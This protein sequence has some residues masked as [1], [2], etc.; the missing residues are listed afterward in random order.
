MDKFN[1]RRTASAISK[2]ELKFCLQLTTSCVS[3][4]ASFLNVSLN[5]ARLSTVSYVV[6]ISYVFIY[7]FFFSQI[8][9]YC[10]AS[11][12]QKR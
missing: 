7:F 12:Y 5:M 3:F 10:I 4:V 2:R 11:G 1:I 9:F 6:K 8:C